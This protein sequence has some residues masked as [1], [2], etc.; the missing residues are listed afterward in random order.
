[1][2]SNSRFVIDKFQSINPLSYEFQDYWKDIKKNC[3]DGLWVDNIWIPPT[4]YFFANI[5]TIKLQN[6]HGKGEYIG[7]PD[8]RP[9]LEWEKHLIFT[10]AKGFSGFELDK[11]YSCDRT[12]L[13]I[14]KLFPKYYTAS[15]D[16]LIKIKEELY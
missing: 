4:L 2:I 3:I 6:L 1:M 7:R 15:D 12:Y 16:E 5:W 9:D 11:E 13:D 10:E 8:I 14:I